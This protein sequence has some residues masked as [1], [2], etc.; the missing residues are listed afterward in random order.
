MIC[1]I[2]GEGYFI[3]ILKVKWL[4]AHFKCHFNNLY[5]SDTLLKLKYSAK[6]MGDNVERQGISVSEI[7]QSMTCT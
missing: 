3:I 1:K 7:P 4:R 6:I 2:G 5:Q